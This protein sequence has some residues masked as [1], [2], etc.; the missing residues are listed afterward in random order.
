VVK[1]DILENKLAV[2]RARVLI[3]MNLNQESCTKASNGNLKLGIH[4]SIFLM[5]QA[6]LFLDS[7]SQ[8]LPDTDL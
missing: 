3:L 4:F 2:F 1:N 6:A 7:R 8:D 5:T